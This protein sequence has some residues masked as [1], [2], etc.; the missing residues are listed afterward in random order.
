MCDELEIYGCT[1]PYALNYN[2]GAT[3]DDASCIYDE[4]ECESDPLTWTINP[5]SFEFNGSLTASVLVD[6]EQVGSENDLLA[7]FVD[8][9][10][11]GV[12][13]GL[14]F[15]PTGDIVFNLMLYSNTVSGEMI[16]FKYYHGASDQVFCLDEAIEFT[17]DMI[18][19]NAL[20]PIQFNIEE[21]FIFSEQIFKINREKN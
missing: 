10:I 11:R 6:G 7:G 19:G 4:I 13:S 3:E 8:D 9:E 15:P 17:A 1:D 2:P 12:I 5:P 14:E 18:L 16:E 20:Q 21:E